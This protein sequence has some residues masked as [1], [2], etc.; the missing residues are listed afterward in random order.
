MDATLDESEELVREMARR[1]CSDMA[2]ASVADFE[3]YDDV[4]AWAALAQSGLLGLRQNDP[5]ATTINLATVVE[6]AAYFTLPVPFLGNSLVGELLSVANASSETLDRFSAGELRLSLGLTSDLRSLW[7][8]SALQSGPPI[9]FD[10]AG[11]AAGVIMDTS[12][13]L[14]LR[15]VAIDPSHTPLDLSRRT[16]AIHATTPIDIGSL[17]GEISPDDF[18]RVMARFLILVCA[19]LVGVIDAGLASAVDYAKGREQFGVA[20]A[21]FQAVQHL[22]ADQLI[23]LEGARSLTEYAA[24]A[25]D[26]LGANEAMLAARTAKAYCSKAG[27]AVTEA[28]VQVYGGMAFTWDCVAHIFLKRAL[29]DAL[30]FGDVDVQIDAVSA[31]REGAER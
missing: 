16:S 22:C 23:T 4:K 9:A 8:V 2:C 6:A 27:R 1:L 29:T 30:L 28:V 26:E 18:D 14:R 11:A 19:D 5:E 24:W 31:L 7:G 15:S 17:G 25:V 12:D 13:G 10:S 21:S 3:S 20:I